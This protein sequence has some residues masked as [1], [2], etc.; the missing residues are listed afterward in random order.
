M[1][2]NILDRCSLSLTPFDGSTLINLTTKRLAFDLLAILVHFK[3]DPRRQFFIRRR[4]FHCWVA[5]GCHAGKCFGDIII[6]FGVQLRFISH[7]AWGAD[8]LFWAKTFEMRFEIRD[9]ESKATKGSS[10]YHVEVAIQTLSNKTNSKSAWIYPNVWIFFLVSLLL[11][12]DQLLA[13]AMNAEVKKP[14]WFSPAVSQYQADTQIISM[15]CEHS[16]KETVQA[17]VLA[18][19]KNKD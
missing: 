13:A 9:M 18:M 14:P 10:T 8:Y 5:A 6:V 17:P 3:E 19:A 11:K 1:Y 4:F 12:L 7:L 2:G 15:G 16:K